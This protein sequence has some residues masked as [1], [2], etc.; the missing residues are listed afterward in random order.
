MEVEMSAKLFWSSKKLVL[1]ALAVMVLLAS[2]LYPV[3]RAGATPGSGVTPEVL[4]A[5][6]LPQEVP[7]KFKAPTGIVQSDV[8][9]ISVIR[10]TIKPGGVFGWHQHGGPLWATVVSGSLTVY[11][12]DDPKCKAEVYPA[13]SV[14]MDP[15]ND[16]HNARNEGREDLVV[17]VTYMLPEGAA[18]RIDIDNPGNCPFLPLDVQYYP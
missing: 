18:P 11:H 14:F 5:G 12:G 6:T 17:L 1:L 4:A 15:G 7:A 10:Y 3:T 2:A 9:Q 16:T 8:S 13:G